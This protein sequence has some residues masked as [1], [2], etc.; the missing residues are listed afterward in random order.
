MSFLNWV[1]RGF[2][3]G[4]EAGRAS[5]QGEGPLFDIRPAVAA[6]ILGGALGL[7]WRGGANPRSLS[8]V[9]SGAAAVLCYQAWRRPA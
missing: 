3:D 4:Y 1:V 2:R 6:A 5:R 8:A 9:A 7:L